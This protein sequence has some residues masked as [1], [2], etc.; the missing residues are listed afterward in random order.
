MAIKDRTVV[1]ETRSGLMEGE[2]INRDRRTGQL[3]VMGENC[4]TYPFQ[5]WQVTSVPYGLTLAEMAVERVARSYTWLQYPTCATCTHPHDER[6]SYRVSQQADG[7]WTCT[8]PAFE[9]RRDECKHILAYAQ[10]NGSIPTAP[11]PKPRPVARTY[12]PG[13]W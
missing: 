7:S 10:V 9:H 8:C 12:A 6:R 1:V 3:M 5:S 2:L 4:K 13:E 11:A